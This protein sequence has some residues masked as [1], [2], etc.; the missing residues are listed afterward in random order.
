MK[1]SGA[2][3][4]LVLKHTDYLS[5]PIT[6]LFDTDF[7]SR[8]FTLLTELLLNQQ[9]VSPIHAFHDNIAIRFMQLPLY[10]SKKD[11][12]GFLGKLDNIM[13]QRWIRMVN[14][15][16]VWYFDYVIGCSPVPY[17]QHRTV[18]LNKMG[19]LWLECTHQGNLHQEFE[20][21]LE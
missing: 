13:Q 10:D 18:Q 15:A 6:C 8:Y 16:R 2:F 21:F 14:T 5:M 17:P 1:F 11:R 20:V 7:N 19:Q 9:P 3:S 4:K 12:I